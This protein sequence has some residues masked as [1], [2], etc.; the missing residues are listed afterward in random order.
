MRR[1]G[2]FTWPKV[3]TLPYSLILTPVSRQSNPLLLSLLTFNILFIPHL[4]VIWF[5]D[6]AVHSPPQLRLGIVKFVEGKSWG[7][8]LVC[9][10]KRGERNQH[11]WL[12][13]Q[14]SPNDQ[15]RW[16]FYTKDGS[17]HLRVEVPIPSHTLPL[18]FNSHHCTTIRMVS[19]IHYQHHVSI[20]SH[21]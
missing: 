1:T 3:C 15:W 14:F 11:A 7:N 12:M 4:L 17:R 2:C 21:Q 19:Y 6:W 8:H 9:G 16:Q 13:T 5:G 20:F 18:C 10:W